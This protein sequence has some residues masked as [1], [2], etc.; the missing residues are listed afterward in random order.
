MFAENNNHGGR[1]LS[2]HPKGKDDGDDNTEEPGELPLP[3]RPSPGS[4]ELTEDE[5]EDHD[6]KGEVGDDHGAEGRGLSARPKRQVR[7]GR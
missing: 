7:F 4:N 1:S 5:E 2:A 3:M 6:Q